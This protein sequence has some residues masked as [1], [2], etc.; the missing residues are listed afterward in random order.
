MFY[1]SCN[2]FRQVAVSL[3]SMTYSNPFYFKWSPNLAKQE[4][5]LKINLTAKATHNISLK[6]H[7][8]PPTDVC[9]PKNYQ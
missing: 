9:G 2:V 7:F 4:S 6:I 8:F 3:I 5:Y 1:L